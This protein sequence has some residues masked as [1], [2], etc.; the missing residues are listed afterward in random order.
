MRQHT[1]Q[2]IYVRVFPVVILLLA[3]LVACGN[4][5]GSERTSSVDVPNVDVPDFGVVVY[6]G[7]DVFGAHETQFSQ[8]FTHGKPVVLNF[9]A[10]LCPPCRAEMPAFQAVADEYADDLIMVGVDVGP[11]IGLGSQDDAQQLLRHLGIR[12][13]AAAAADMTPLQLYTVQGMPTTIF[14]AP[15]GEI[16]EKRTGLLLETQLRSIVAELVARTP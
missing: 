1:R 11:Y 7:D 6:Q 5:T 14:F 4:G 10:G 3:L 13:P 8:V 16:V 12:Y 9:W 2:S 15:N